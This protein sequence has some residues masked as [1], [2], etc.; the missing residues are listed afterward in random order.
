MSF[1]Q[2]RTGAAR[3]GIGQPVPRKEDE[4]LLRGAGCYSDDVNLA[5]QAYAYV[6]RSPHAH[7]RIRGI[8]SGEALAAPGVIAVPTGHDAAADGLQP[9]PHRPV[10]TNPHEVL[11]KNRDGSPLFI[12]PYP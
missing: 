9:I 8:D 5:G 4:R 1:L 10:T 6:V 11:L 7:A 3:E 2:S 12:A